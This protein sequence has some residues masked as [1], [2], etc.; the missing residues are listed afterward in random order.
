MRKRFGLIMILMLAGP[1]RAG[2]DIPPPDLTTINAAIA[3]VQAQVPQAAGTVPPM[4]TASGSAG[5]A[6][7][8]TPGNAIRMRQSRTGSCSLAANTATCSGTWDGGG[9]P[10]GST[11]QN[12]GDPGVINTAGGA[13]YICNYTAV[14]ISGF[15]VSCQ[16]AQSTLL[17]LTIVTS[18][19]TISPFVTPSAAITVTATGITKSQ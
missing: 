13:P 7:T 15:S 8:Y 9:F 18:G 16:R 17:S 14:S 6:G 10:S 5:T 2:I 12:I 11:V 4:D 1:A 19:L 3:A